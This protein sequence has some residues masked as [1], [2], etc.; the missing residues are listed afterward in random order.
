M[1]SNIY[2]IA[3]TCA[4]IAMFF[5]IRTLDKRIDITRDDVILLSIMVKFKDMV[6]HTKDPK[7]LQKE[8][9]KI[10]GEGC[11]KVEKIKSNKRG[12]K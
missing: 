11:V 12:K 8:L 1:I 2:M 10:V 6:K 3:T 9:E 5:Y 7:K 4:I